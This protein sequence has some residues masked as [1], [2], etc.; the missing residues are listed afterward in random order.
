ML[1]KYW[2]AGCIAPLLKGHNV[3]NLTASITGI[4]ALCLIRSAL[5]IV[6]PGTRYTRACDRRLMDSIQLPIGLL[7]MFKRHRLPLLLLLLPD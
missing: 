2:Y 6:D 1:M 4:L 7:M 3:L 5:R